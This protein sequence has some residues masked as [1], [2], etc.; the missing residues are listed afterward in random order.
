MVID[1]ILSVLHFL[2]V[3]VV[4]GTLAI[5][6]ASV[7]PGMSRDTAQRIARIDGLYGLSAVILVVIGFLRVYFGLKPPEFYFESHAFWTKLG[8]FIL[9]A[10]ASVPPTIAFLRWSRSIKADAAFEVPAGAIANVRRWLHA[11]AALLVFIPILAAVM[12]RGIG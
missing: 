1:T 12:A 2:A 4:V 6:L 10:L 5:E 8:L 9:I 7:R 3:F 11:E